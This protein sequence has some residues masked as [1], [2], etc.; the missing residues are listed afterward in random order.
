MIPDWGGLGPV[1]GGES[2]FCLATA[3]A[4]LAIENTCT[5][6]H[7]RCRP[8]LWKKRC[9]SSNGVTGSQSE[10]GRSALAHALQEP[11]HA[12]VCVCE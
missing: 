1:D 7:G 5:C 2:S 6:H 8:S 3:L 4:I 12:L 10:A 11:L 9:R